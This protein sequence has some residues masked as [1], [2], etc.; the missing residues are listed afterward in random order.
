MPD[1]LSR[2]ADYRPTAEDRERNLTQA[3]PTFAESNE[4]FDGITS[5]EQKLRAVQ[6]HREID[7]EQLIQEDD[8]SQG[9]VSSRGPSDIADSRRYARRHLPTMRSPNA[10]GVEMLTVGQ[11]AWLTAA[12]ACRACKTELSGNGVEPSWSG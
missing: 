4:L 5:T 3:L 1:A 7:E 8:L 11:L 9:L 10:D 2:R 6:R 12:K